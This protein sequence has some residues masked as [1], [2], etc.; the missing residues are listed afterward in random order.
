MNPDIIVVLCG[1][2]S[3]LFAFFHA[4][5][6]KLLNWKI[7]LKKLSYPNRGAVQMLNIQLIIIFLLIAFTCFVFTKDLYTTQIGK[8]LLTGMSLFWLFRFVEQ[9]IFLR[10]NNWLVNLLTVSFAAGAILFILPVVF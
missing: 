4:G 10:M 8:V 6:W 2:H 3:L 9:F 5:F 1:V 7:E